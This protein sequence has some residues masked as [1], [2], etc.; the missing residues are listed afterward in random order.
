VTLLTYPVS[1]ETGLITSQNIV[2]QPLTRRMK[3]GS[4]CTEAQRLFITPMIYGRRCSSMW[5]APS[6]FA[7]LRAVW[8]RVYVSPLQP[9]AH[10]AM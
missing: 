4:P 1:S 7:S 6:R 5:M 3:T 10:S 2:S 9:Q 8:W